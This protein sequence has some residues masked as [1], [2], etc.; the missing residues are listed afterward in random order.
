MTQGQISAAK[1][2]REAVERL[3]SSMTV[4]D[5]R[6]ALVEAK[7]ALT[8]FEGHV[9]DSLVSVQK[10]SA[11]CEVLAQLEELVRQQEQLRQQAETERNRRLRGLLK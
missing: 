8:N 1:T 7:T 11:F 4:K 10:A 2:Y 5:R 6:E 3:R 9:K